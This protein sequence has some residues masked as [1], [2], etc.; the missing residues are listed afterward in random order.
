MDCACP[1]DQTRVWVSVTH[2]FSH[3]LPYKII[4]WVGTF[5]PLRISSLFRVMG[6]FL[7]FVL[8]RSLTWAQ[9][10]PDW[11]Y[12][13]VMNTGYL[14]KTLNLTCQLLKSYNNSL[15]KDCWLSFSYYS[16]V[17]VSVL[18]WATS[19]MTFHPKYQEDTLFSKWILK[20]YLISKSL[21][22]P[23]TLLQGGLL[24]S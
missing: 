8:T 21:I 4:P 16:A 13:E 19:K 2:Y 9:G 23:K 5:L 22:R 10:T 17:V 3:L 15:A 12:Q 20:T 24:F 1:R 7:L 18:Q 6:K 14:Y 11:F